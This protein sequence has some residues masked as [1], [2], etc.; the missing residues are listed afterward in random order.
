MFANLIKTCLGDDLVVLETLTYLHK[1]GRCSAVAA[2]GANILGLKPCIEV[3]QGKMGV[4]KKYRGKMTRVLPE[5]VED[6]K[7]DLMNVI[8]VG[9][10]AT[11]GIE[12]VVWI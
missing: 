7:E 11:L 8:L 5:Y 6:M 12:G 3:H 4:G 1:G 10:V 2:L 9:N